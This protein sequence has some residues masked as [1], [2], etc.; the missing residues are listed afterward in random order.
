MACLYRAYIGMSYTV[1]KLLTSA[2]QEIAIF[3]R[4]YYKTVYSVSDEEATRIEENVY[5][6]DMVDLEPTYF[7]W[8]FKV[9]P[10]LTD[11]DHQGA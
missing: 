4:R 5:F 2:G 7:G 3:Y 8:C 6:L 9:V 11:Y 1:G 10:F